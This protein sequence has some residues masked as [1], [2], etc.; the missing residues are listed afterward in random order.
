MSGSGEATKINEGWIPLASPEP[1]VR[2]ALIIDGT[3]HGF[4][5]GMDNMPKTEELQR[6]FARKM[7]RI[8][9]ET[10]LFHYGLIEEDNE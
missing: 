4:S 2:L 6:E 1:H 3:K 9:E 8:T 7:G 10:L 5:I